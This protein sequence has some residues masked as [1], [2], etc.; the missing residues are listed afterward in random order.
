MF[1]SILSIMRRSIRSFNI[2][3]LG[4]LNFWGLARSNSRPLPPGQ[5]CLQISLLILKYTF[6]WSTNDVEFSEVTSQFFVLVLDF[7][8]VSII[9]WCGNCLSHETR[10]LAVKLL[11]YSTCITLE[12]LHTSSSNAP[13]HH[14]KV[15]IIL[16]LGTYSVQMPVG[17]PRGCW[18]F[19]VT[20]I[21]TLDDQS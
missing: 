2:P 9:L 10:F 11:H 1:G 6:I 20:S 4:Y 7:S 17:C 21:S 16:P 12:R 18:S 5:N 13:P 19:D 15:Q 3:S 8:L 14:G